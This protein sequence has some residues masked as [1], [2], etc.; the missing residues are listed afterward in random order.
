MFHNICCLFILLFLCDLPFSKK[1]EGEKLFFRTMAHSRRVILT[2]T[3]AFIFRIT[4]DI[5]HDKMSAHF[6]TMPQI[7]LFSSKLKNIISPW[8]FYSIN[9]GCSSGSCCCYCSL[10]H[11]CSVFLLCSL[12]MRSFF[13][14]PSSRMCMNIFP[15]KF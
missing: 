15:N 2:S 11:L 9:C 13:L 4:W 1:D 5:F 7:W 8:K 14:S 10:F 6:I 3:F 12:W